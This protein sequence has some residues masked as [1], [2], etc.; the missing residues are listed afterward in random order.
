LTC[1]EFADFLDDYLSAAMPAEQRSRVEEH[2]AVCPDCQHYL[3]SYQETIRLGKAAFA[4][5][6]ERVPASVPED[7]LAAIRAA[8]ASS[9]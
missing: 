4:S 7:L 9:R 1:K 5:P 8:R 6:D 2:L 3:A